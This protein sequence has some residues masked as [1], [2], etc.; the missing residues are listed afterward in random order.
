MKKILIIILLSI[1]L[2]QTNSF[3]Q[4]AM[5]GETART[6]LKAGNNSAKGLNAGI[7][8]L[9]LGPYVLLMT[10]GI[11]WYRARKKARA[12]ANQNNTLDID[13]LIK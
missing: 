6:S 12:Q 3:A 1:A 11:L 13:A 4:C 2:F 8:Y 9:L 7:A 5:C 10:G